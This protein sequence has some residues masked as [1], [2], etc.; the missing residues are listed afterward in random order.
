MPFTRDAFLDVFAAYNQAVWPWALGLWVLTAIVF[1]AFVVR[2]RIPQAL[3]FY[4]L[5]VQ[6]G[7]AGLIYHAI[8]FTAINPAAWMFAALFLVQG[9]ILFIAA[10]SGRTSFQPPWTWRTGFSSVLIVYALAY[11]AVVWADGFAYPRM[12]TFGVPCP[13]AILTIGF[14]LAISTSSL[15]VATIPVLWSLIAGSAA[16][17]FGVHADL[18]LP[19]AGIVLAIDLAL[20]RSHVMRKLSLAG[21]LAFLIGVPVF[22]A[23]QQHQHEQQAQTAQAGD[24]KTG[25]M[26]MGKMKMAGMQMGDMMEK[27]KA[28]NARLDALMAQVKSSSGEAKVNAMAEVIALLLEERTAMQDHCATACSMMKK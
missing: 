12:P 5:A 17:L 6:W 3:P 1:V 10:Q 22:A 28:A 11:P 20:R 4:V 23:P 8:F 24:A 15:P 2:M 13:T 21:F 26:K 9:I 25:E 7:W 27:K 14:L 18:A 16:W 19:V